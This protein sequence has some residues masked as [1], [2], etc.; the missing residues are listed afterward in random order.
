MG[1]WLCLSYYVLSENREFL[2][3]QSK[4]DWKFKNISMQERQLCVQKIANPNQCVCE[5]CAMSGPSGLNHCWFLEFILLLSSKQR[6][7]KKSPKY[8][9]TLGNVFNVVCFELGQLNWRIQSIRSLCFFQII[10]LLKKKNK[11][12]VIP[13]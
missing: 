4:K 6:R 7:F 5:T 12:Y 8:Q 1:K 2:I 10:K 9:Q 13:K 11:Q 3:M